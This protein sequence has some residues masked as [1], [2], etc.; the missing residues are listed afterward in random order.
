MY[1]EVSDR[2]QYAIKILPKT[3]LRALQES[4]LSTKL[5]VEYTLNLHY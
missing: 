1:C 5:S 3:V 4:L 2:K